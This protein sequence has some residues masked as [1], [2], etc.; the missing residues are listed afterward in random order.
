MAPQSRC[1]A[2]AF[3]STPSVGRATG[4]FR[5][6][7]DEP[8]ISIHALRGEGDYTVWLAWA[9]LAYFYPR[10]PWGGRRA[11]RCCA[12]TI[13]LFLSTP[14]VGRATNGRSKWHKV[15]AFLSTPSVGRAT[16]SARFDMLVSRISIHALRGEGDLN[17]AVWQVFQVDFYP[18]PPWGGRLHLRRAF[19]QA[20]YFYPRPPWGGRRGSAWKMRD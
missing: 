16:L 9:G 3:L 13:G 2:A 8:L 4:G 11:S 20:A 15:R 12:F 14:S 1:G 17:G 19:L 10:P 5:R 6:F 7:V 18:R